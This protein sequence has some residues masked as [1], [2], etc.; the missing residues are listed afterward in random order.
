[1]SVALRVVPGEFDLAWAGRFA[2]AA[3]VQPAVHANLGADEV[4]VRLSRL[5]AALQS[6]QDSAAVLAASAESPA[7]KGALA[8]ARFLLGRLRT[9]W[10]ASGLWNTEAVVLQDA[11]EVEAV[12]DELFFRLRS[13]ERAT[14]LRAGELPAGDAHRLN[15][16]CD[17]L[18]SAT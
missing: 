14:R 15:L 2:D 16:L 6:A 10:N 3:H 11:A 18:G 1:V 7:L 13:I 8:L 5:D 4:Q 9:G 17:G 12:E